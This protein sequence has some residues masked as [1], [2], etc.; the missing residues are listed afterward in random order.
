MKINLRLANCYSRILA[1][2]LGKVHI[3]TH[4]CL[5]NLQYFYDVCSMYN[6]SITMYSTSCTMCSTCKMYS[7]YVQCMSYS[8][9]EQCT[10][11]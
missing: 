3:G 5:Y 8:V 2:L 9:Q 4:R 10:V 7:M 1:S 11:F 6:K